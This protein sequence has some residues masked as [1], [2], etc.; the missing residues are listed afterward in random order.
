[1]QKAESMIRS[2]PIDLSR[3]QVADVVNQSVGRSLHYP[4]PSTTE[5]Q[6]AGPSH[7]KLPQPHDCLQLADR[8]DVHPNQIT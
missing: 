4:Q 2:S 1:M 5:Q 8:F 3:L 7:A 6:E